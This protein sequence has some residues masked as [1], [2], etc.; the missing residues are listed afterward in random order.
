MNMSLAEKLLIFFQLANTLW[1]RH[2]NMHKNLRSDV[3]RAKE[4][5]SVACGAENTTI[6]SYQV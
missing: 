1:W 4:Q 5:K 2:E 6:D 3:T